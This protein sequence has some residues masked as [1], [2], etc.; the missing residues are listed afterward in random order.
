MYPHERRSQ[1]NERQTRLGTRISPEDSRERQPSAYTSY[2]PR[3]PASKPTLEGE[4]VL[5][6][7]GKT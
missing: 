6:W 3:D 7:N 2:A 5:E 1:P 4:N